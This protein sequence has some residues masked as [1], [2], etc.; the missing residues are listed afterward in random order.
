MC[1]A[2]LPSAADD[3]IPQLSTQFDRSR[4]ALA[5]THW[6]LWHVTQTERVWWRIEEAHRFSKQREWGNGET[7]RSRE[8]GRLRI[9]LVVEIVVPHNAVCHLMLALFLRDHPIIQALSFKTRF[10][11][12]TS[13]HL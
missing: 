2:A 3:S 11:L 9:S 7:L 10:S 1:A 5:D 12:E 6:A 13:S 8:S 4:S